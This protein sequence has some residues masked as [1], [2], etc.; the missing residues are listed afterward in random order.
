MDNYRLT[1][2]ADTTLSNIND[3]ISSLIQ[4][5]DE[6]EEIISDLKEKIESYEIIMEDLNDKIDFL[7]EQLNNIE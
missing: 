4:E 1:K 2:E 6:K 3:L 7:E 5:V